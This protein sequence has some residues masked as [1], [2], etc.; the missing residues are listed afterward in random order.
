MFSAYHLHPAVLRRVRIGPVGLGGL[1]E[2]SSRPLRTE[3]IR[4]LLN[5][6]NQW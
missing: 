3:E 6:G 4:A 2:G 5:G 1:E